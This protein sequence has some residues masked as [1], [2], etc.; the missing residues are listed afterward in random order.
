V[1]ISNNAQE[2]TL[3]TGLVGEYGAHNWSLIAK[4]VPGRSGKSCRL[5]W[6]NQ[7]NPEL[8]KAPFSELEDAQIIAAHEKIGNRWAII[9]RHL[10]GRTDN[11]IKNH[12]NSTL[13]R[14]H[15]SRSYPRLGDLEPNSTLVLPKTPS[16]DGRSSDDSHYDSDGSS[17]LTTTSI[18][19]APPNHCFKISRKHK[20]QACSLE[21]GG[22][23]A[24]YRKTNSM[25]LGSNDPSSIQ[26]PTG[27]SDKDALEGFRKDQ[28]CSADET[29]SFQSVQS[30]STSAAANPPMVSGLT[31]SRFTDTYQHLLTQCADERS[32]WSSESIN[33]EEF[34]ANQRCGEGRR[35]SH[36]DPVLFFHDEALFQVLDELD[37]DFDL[38]MWDK[39]SCAA[40]NVH[41]GSIAEFLNT[42]APMSL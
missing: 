6:L 35:E 7:L 29:S 27:T 9:A 10:P 5:R 16:D 24:K 23:P 11:A 19:P 33:H 25:T 32:P 38:E 15:L 26:A 37:V 14:K 13:E 41:R 31:S 30:D 22:P 39:D 36:N 28:T 40:A 21:M 4:G 12:W 20:I 34:S 1:E 42:H 18:L 17:E 3:L 2:D 8:N